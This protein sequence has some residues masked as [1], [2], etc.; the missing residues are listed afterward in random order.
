M[1]WR[2]DV[3]ERLIA[4][5]LKEEGLDDAGLVD[6]GVATAVGLSRG[7]LQRIVQRRLHLAAVELA[8]VQ[9]VDD[10]VQDRVLDDDDVLG[11]IL[12]QRQQAA[13]GVEPRVGAQFLV[14]RLQAL[15]D[16]RHAE[17]VVSL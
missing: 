16:A 3:L 15:D 2:A 4:N 5:D 13:F 17:L 11:H 14:E 8:A 10:V 1:C 12:Q 7:G 9:K 6:D